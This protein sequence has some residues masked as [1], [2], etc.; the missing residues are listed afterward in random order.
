MNFIKNHYKRILFLFTIFLLIILIGLSSIGR[1]DGVNLGFLGN[2]VS[3]FQKLTF[4][5]G[6]TLTNSF[7]SVQEIVRM[8]EENIMLTDNVHELKEQVR[9][10]E[11]IVNKSDALKTEYEMKTNLSYDYIV[12]QVIALDDSN[13]FSRFTI[14][15]GENDGLKKND[16]VI[17]A[18]ETENGVVQIGLVGIVVETSS[19]WSKVITL[20]DE[21]CKISFRDINSDESGIIQGSIDGTVAGYFFNSKAKASEGDNIVTSGIG[22]IYVPDIYIGDVKEVIQT[23]D[24][25]TQKV[26]VEPA[27][28]FTKLNRV[29][30][31]KVSK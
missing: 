19:N 11:N 14:D 16:I 3:G 22:E 1:M 23:T 25:S 24:A 13:W 30:V 5:T 17:Y 8:R 27:V 15:K 2:V 31:L 9:F 4:N 6:Q 18:V 29:Y 28:E 7:F 20:L 21:S 12:G 26:V 10:L